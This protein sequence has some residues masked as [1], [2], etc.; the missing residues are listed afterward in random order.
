[1]ETDDDVSA[2]LSTFFQEGYMT[3]MEQVKRSGNIHHYIIRLHERRGREEG[4]RRGRGG[5][6]GGG[7]EGGREGER[8]ERGIKYT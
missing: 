3:D 2:K 8:E 1:M 6:G 5:R 4:E 7:K